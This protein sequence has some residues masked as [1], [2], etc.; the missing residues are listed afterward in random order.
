LTIWHIISPEYPPASGGVADYTRLV[1]L[2]LAADGDRVHVW[3]PAVPGAELSEPGGEV[4]RL[5]GRFGLQALAALSRELDAAGPGH[6]LVQYVPQGFGMNGMNLLF[7]LWLLK[8]RRRDVTIMFHEV[9]VA[10]TR[11][12]PLRHNVIGLVNRAMGVVLTRAAGRCFVGAAAWEG[13]LRPLAPA[14]CAIT[15]LPVPSNL[16][17]VDNPEGVR[18]IRRSLMVEGGTV[19]GHFGTARERWIVERLESCVL[20]LLRER[21]GARLLLLG[22]DSREQRDRLLAGAPEIHS[23]VRAA[24]PLAP[25]DLS[26]H[27]C[28]CDM[29]I[30]PYGDG[31]TTRRGSMMAALSHRRPVV[32]TAGYLTEPLWA[33][34]G[35]VAMADVGDAAAMRA[36]IARLMDDAEERARLSAAASALYV[37]RFDVA[38]TIAALREVNTA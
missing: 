33:Q 10:L 16:P 36:A 8:Q 25:G 28:A 5:P 32:T 7:C 6:I 14:G 31:V 34:S 12:Q 26:L 2:G 35:A 17:V 23:R 21:P 20:P 37:E 27:L 11:D 38:H 29:M 1:A 9:A 13:M 19:L 24:G 15:W 30:Q 4:H 18:A 3:T 22:R